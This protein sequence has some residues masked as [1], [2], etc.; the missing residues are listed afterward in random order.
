[1]SR[2]EQVKSRVYE[3]QCLAPMAREVYKILPGM[4]WGVSRLLDIRVAAEPNGLALAYLDERYT[5]RD[6]DRKANQYAR[7]FQSRGIGQGDTVAL[8]M[9]NRPDFIFIFQALARLRAVASLINTNVS[10]VTATH[11]INICK[12]K[13]V[14]VGSEHA[15]TLLEV[16]PTLQGVSGRLWF[17]A[18]NAGDETPAELERINEAVSQQ[19]D[20]RPIGLTTPS[21]NDTV[22]LIYTSG[23]TGLPKAAII[24]NRRYLGGALL[25]G[26]T[27][28]QSTS[29][30]ILYLPLP[31]YHSNA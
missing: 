8:L 31:L 6:L 30:D 29:R 26:L 21:S 18:E 28:F 13:A 1:M 25:F 17:Q 5:W 24:T 10:G 14:L 22:C 15:S 2:L 27:M 3:L 4:P 23:T 11:A 9:D 7:F 12:A 20:A 16:L 19:S